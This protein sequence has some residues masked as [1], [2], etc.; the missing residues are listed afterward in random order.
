MVSSSR[1]FVRVIDSA[2]NQAELPLSDVKVLRHLYPHTIDA[3]YEILE[4]VRIPVGRL[5]DYQP[6]LDL[7]SLDEALE[8]DMTAL[9]RSG[10][11]IVTDLE[12]AQ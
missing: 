10:S 6:A 9:D 7:G 1:I 4:T 12:F 11:V 5:L 3:I 8:L 2:G